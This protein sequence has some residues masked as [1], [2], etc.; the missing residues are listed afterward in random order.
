MIQLEPSTVALLMFVLL[1]ALIF[2]G[3]PL[4]FCIGGI[5]MFAG[6][7]VIGPSATIPLMYARAY[8]I[9]QDYM[10]LAV[11]MFIFMGLMVQKSGVADNLFHTLQLWVGRVPGS[12]AI[13]TI[14]TGALIAATVG[15]FSASIIMLGLTGLPAMMK[16][17]YNK[18]LAYGS[19]IAGGCLG[20]LIP[21]S[22]MLVIYGPMSSL[23]V[24]KLFMGAFGAGVSLALFYVLYILVRCAVTPNYAPTISL[25]EQRVPMSTKLRLLVTS[26]L[27]PVF[28]ILAVLGSIFFGVAAPTEA[29]GIGALAS[30]MLVA[31][32]KK[33]SWSVLTDVLYT[34]FKLSGFIIILV[35]GASI[36]TGIFLRLGG[37]KVVADLILASPGGK[38]G[39]FALLMLIIFLLGMFL[40]WI[41]ILL[42]IVPIVTPIGSALG[43]HPIW[44]AMMI[45]I[46]LQMAYMTPP[47]APAIFILRGTLPADE[48]VGATMPI[49]RGVIPFIVLVMIFIALCIAVP[50]IVTWLPDNMIR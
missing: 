19:V 1:F 34:T 16:A 30:L 50:D 39:A 17:N 22:I 42:I 4:A 15:V 37:G 38:W 18:G 25:E 41:G 2:T 13:V 35:I 44:F 14:M 49:I 9:L 33:L 32:Y 47:F 7:L 10:L 8:G 46:N 48:A 11:P 36:F 6:F 3:Y 43:F 29:A 24:G 20:I 26:L 21:P 23:S 45:C 12:L 31:A 5:G 27:P 40:D 28:L